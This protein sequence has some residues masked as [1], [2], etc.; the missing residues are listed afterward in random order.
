MYI[1]SFAAVITAVL[2]FSSCA[3]GAE[4]TAESSA[5]ETTVSSTASNNA[6][7]DALREKYPEYFE[8][9]DFKGIEIYIWQTAEDEYYCG[10][11]SG[12]NR[13][14]TDEE[15]HALAEKPLTVDEAKAILDAVGADMDSIFVIPVIQPNSD[16]Q[17]EIDEEFTDRVNALF[18]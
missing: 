17:Y 6:E 18:R 14:K 11:M 7:I 16:Y 4:D 5:A 8:I 3:A 2:V 1:K 9:S 12:T 15:I 10:L 13:N